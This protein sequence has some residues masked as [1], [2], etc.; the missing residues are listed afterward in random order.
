MNFRALVVLSLTVCLLGNTVAVGQSGSRRRPKRAARNEG[1]MSLAIAESKK[2]GLPIFA[3]STAKSCSA[4]ASLLMTMETDE[5][6]QPTLKQFVFLKLD[7]QESDFPNWNRMYPRE[8]N[9]TPAWHVVTSKGKQLE[10]AVGAPSGAELNQILLTSLEKAGRLPSAETMQRLIAAAELADGHLHAGREGEALAAMMPVR[11]EFVQFAESLSM[12][13]GGRKVL[14]V[15][16]KI[17]EQG[18]EKV[19][20]L[21]QRADNEGDWQTALEIA[22]VKHT[23]GM[24]PTLLEEIEGVVEKFI[25]NRANLKLYRAA[26]DLQRAEFLLKDGGNLKKTQSALKRV[27]TRHPNTEA[28]TAAARMLITGMSAKSTEAVATSTGDSLRDWTDS[29]GKHTIRARLVGA[30]GEQIRLKRP[31]GKVVSVP[32]SKLDQAAQQYLSEHGKGSR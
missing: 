24:L 9:A 5:S 28:A 11:E 29:T 23:Y 30:N 22:H 20:V 10:S 1:A 21:A 12:S 8:Q 15:A 14:Q 3:V 27:I 16:E 13:E 2:S 7:V 19:Q 31:N 32:I 4:C 17:S 6:L 26:L 18:Q 25:S